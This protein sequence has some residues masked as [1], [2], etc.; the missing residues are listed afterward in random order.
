MIQNIA[1]VIPAGNEEVL[2]GSC[3]HAIAEA[4][5]HAHCHVGRALRIRTIVV[6]DRCVDATASAVGGWAGVESIVSEAGCVGV[7]RAQGVE[8]ALAGVRADA[9]CLSQIWIANS[10]ADSRVPV[11]W[12]TRML[13]E[14]DRGAQ[15]VLGTV[16]PGDGLSAIRR[17]LWR[18]RHQLGDGHLHVHGANLG[19]RA[20]AYMALGGWPALASGEDVVL[21]GRA[22]A[23]ADM[24]IVS[25]GAIP[26]L[27]SA[28]LSGRAPHGFATYLQD[29][30]RDTF[31]EP[32][33]QPFGFDPA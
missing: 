8:H 5:R 33:E 24:R 32:D 10:D 12:I 14:A 1:I 9:G 11:D 15:L 22:R 31:R 21:A 13:G 7:A 19:I 25:T 27:T 18:E 2:I 6:L 29:L 3:L 20:D 26:V 30:V 28:R 23:T 16:A 17:R 4:R